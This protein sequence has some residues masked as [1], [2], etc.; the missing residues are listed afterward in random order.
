MRII[1]LILILIVVCGLSIAQ[2]PSNKE[3]TRDCPMD[4]WYSLGGFTPNSFLGFSDAPAKI[5]ATGWSGF[6]YEKT[7]LDLELENLSGKTIKAVKVKWFI[8]RVDKINGVVTP[9]EKPKFILQGET[10]S[11]E[12]NDFKAKE[13]KLI[14]YWIGSCR[15]VYEAYVEDGETEGEPWLES[16]I[17]EILYADGSKWTR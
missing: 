16:T 17:T 14:S 9:R 3:E 4:R 13:R 1:Q 12:T 7:P 2:K 6:G 15:E 8:F 11:I 5:V 10:P